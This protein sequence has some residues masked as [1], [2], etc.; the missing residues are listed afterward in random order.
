MKN[1]RKLK[2]FTL[3]ELIVVVV[4]IGILA[5]IGIAGYNSVTKT[6]NEN[7]DA[8]D[9]RTVVSVLSANTAE[10]GEQ[11]VGAYLGDATEGQAILDA[12]NLDD[13]VVLTYDGTVISFDGR[14]STG[15]IAVTGA[16]AQ[17]GALTPDA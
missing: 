16:V 11:T 15:T 2:G 8:A 4:I 14:A 6:A 9:A 17:L 12:L 7:A 10:A 1:L 5:T 13:S 3:I